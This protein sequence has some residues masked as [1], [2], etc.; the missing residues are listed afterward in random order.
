MCL[1]HVEVCRIPLEVT[2]SF[3]AFATSSSPSKCPHVENQESWSNL[4][5]K[6]S[7]VLTSFF[8]VYFNKTQAT[9]H[10]NA[11]P[12]DSPH[13]GA[14]LVQAGFLQLCRVRLS[15]ACGSGSD[16]GPM[17]CSWWW[18]VEGTRLSAAALGWSQRD[19][20]RGMLPSRLGVVESGRQRARGL[21]LFRGICG[22]VGLSAIVRCP[23]LSVNLCWYFPDSLSGV[24]LR[25]RPLVSTPAVMLLRRDR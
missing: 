12:R 24:P 9:L 1:L 19:D 23:S 5:T 13:P 21:G 25:A 8:V 3:F 7:N 16:F 2:R 18:V 17:P 14:R 4:L 6:W 15:A 10:R 20:S 11:V 22:W